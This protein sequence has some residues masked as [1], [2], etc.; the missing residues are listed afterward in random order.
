MRCFLVCALSGELRH[1]MCFAKHKAA[2]ED[3]SHIVSDE[4][5]LVY[6]RVQQFMYRPGQV[7]RASAG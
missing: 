7:H 4:R 1:Y 6:I 2:L 5:R 3:D